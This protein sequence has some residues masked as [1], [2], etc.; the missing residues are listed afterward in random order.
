MSS[1]LTLNLGLRYDFWPANREANNLLTSFDPAKK[2][3]VLGTDLNTMYRLNATIPSVVN[4][5]QSLGVKFI[6]YKDAGMPQT[7]FRVPK[8]DFGP[9]LGFAY[10]MGAGK[11]EIV[12]R[13]GYRISRA[14]LADAILASLADP[15]AVGAT[16]V[17]GY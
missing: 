5:M 14:D 8:T 6:S 2:A 13:G 7:L 12:L 10:R 1:R 17:L 11:R 15:T 3:I 9:R 16:I 4:R